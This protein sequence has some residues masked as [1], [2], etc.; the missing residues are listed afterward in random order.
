MLQHNQDPK[1]LGPMPPLPQPLPEITI[2]ALLLVAREELQRLDLPYPTVEAITKSLPGTRSSA[3]ALVPRLRE[4]LANLARPQ[5]RPPKPPV[6]P[7]PPQITKAILGFLMDHPGAVSGGPGHRRYSDEFRLFTLELLGKYKEISLPSLAESAEIPLGTLKDWLAGG[8]AAVVTEKQAMPTR[9]DPR[10][11]QIATV[12]AEWDRWQGGFRN[13]CDHIQH[14]CRIPFSRSIL[15][16][17]LDRDGVRIP[18]KR[19]GRSPDEDALRNRFHTFFPHAQWVADG[20]IVPVEVNGKTFVFNVELAVDAYSGAFTGVGISRFEDSAGVIAAYN[21]GVTS[22]G[23]RPIALL[24]DNKACNHTNSVVEALGDT[25]L[26]PAT[27]QRPQNKAHVEG[28]FGLLQPTLD[29]LTFQHGDSEESTARSFLRALMITAGRAWNGRPR[30]DRNLRSRLD[31]LEDRPS[32]EQID[33]ARK[34]LAELL[35]KQKA[36]RETTAK[37]QNPNVR[38]LI[39]LSYQRLGLEDPHGA[40][41]TATAR[42]SLSAVAEGIAIFE[43]KRRAETLPEGVG[44]EYLLGIV[45]NVAQESENWEIALALWDWRTRAKDELCGRLEQHREAID[46]KASDDEERV[47][48]YVDKATATLART[49]RFFWLQATA[50]LISEHDE[51]KTTF[52]LAARRIAA[53]HKLPLRD[54]NAATRFLAARCV[55]LD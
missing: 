48:S 35:A 41:L 18:N 33:A 49:E 42:Y 29:G 5:G 36:A 39:A 24:L 23:V 20:W 8:S 2:F 55:E 1:P 45:R 26:I 40:N 43:G 9:I 14:H 50:D 46:D 32:Q 10:G 21:D 31:L 52:R 22:S 19:K 25:L 38:A 47:K 37:R 51:P 11:P 4:M 53:H 3:Y 34:E 16:A 12:L 17:I 44:A 7:A 15:A 30:K 6:E 13:F 28:A 54:R 27:L